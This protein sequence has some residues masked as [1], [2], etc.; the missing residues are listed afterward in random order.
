MAPENRSHCSFFISRTRLNAIN[1]TPAQ[2]IPRLFVRSILG[3]LQLRIQR[4]APLPAESLR[5]NDVPHVHRNQISRQKIK[6]I[7]LIRTPAAPPRAR[8]TATI[9]EHRRLHLDPHKMPFMLSEAEGA[10]PAPPGASRLAAFARR[11]IPNRRCSPIT[12]AN[13]YLMSS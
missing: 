2:Q 10:S 4:N 12:D 5:R 9:F 6:R 1:N 7:A 13:P 3:L 11:G 8:I